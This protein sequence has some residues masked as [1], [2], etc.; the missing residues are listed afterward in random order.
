M[1]ARMGSRRYNSS[2]FNVGAWYVWVDN[3]ST[4]RLPHPTK[5]SGVHRS[6][7]PRAGL[8]SQPGFDPR[9]VQ[10][11]ASCSLY[12]GFRKCYWW[13]ESCCST[14]ENTLCI[15]SIPL[16]II[17]IWCMWKRRVVRPRPIRPHVWNSFP[18][19]P[20]TKILVGEV[21]LQTS[22]NTVSIWKWLVQGRWQKMC[23]RIPFGWISR[24][25]GQRK[26]I[27][28]PLMVQYVQARMWSAFLTLLWINLAINCY[29]WL[30]GRVHAFG[31][32]CVRARAAGR[33]IGTAQPSLLWRCEATCMN[34]HIVHCNS[35]LYVQAES[36]FVDRVVVLTEMYQ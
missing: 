25:L 11:V 10:P 5:R 4:G 17:W 24:V 9:T 14:E 29:V 6:G 32:S 16:T 28:V 22:I 2:V 21:I 12:Y 30:V 33:L 15:M 27:S 18:Q 36:N 13:L 20:L 31:R 23:L 3:A 19:T 8:A 7:G 35:Q 26:V 34:A 1:R